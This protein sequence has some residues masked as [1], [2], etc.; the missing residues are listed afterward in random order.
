MEARKKILIV[1]D[2]FAMRHILKGILQQLGRFS[3]FEASNGMQA[4]DI[5]LA[6]KPDLVFLDIIMP[7]LSGIDTLKQKFRRN[8]IKD[9]PVIICTAEGSYKRVGEILKLG[10]VDYIL[11]PFMLET[12][13]LKARKWLFDEDDI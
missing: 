11:K 2:E 1:D 13:Q 8:E 7:V 6:E 4:I 5:M 9:I 10:V 12:V 3:F